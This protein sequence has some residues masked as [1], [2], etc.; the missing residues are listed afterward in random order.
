MHFI[1]IYVTPYNI[2]REIGDVIRISLLGEVSFILLS[3]VILS[4][5]GRDSYEKSKKKSL[6]M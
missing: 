4:L 6:N 5:I 1:I 2:F 3:L